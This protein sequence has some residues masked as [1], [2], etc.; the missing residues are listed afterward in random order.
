PKET[1]VNAQLH[2][3]RNPASKS[4]EKSLNLDGINM[5]LKEVKINKKNLSPKDYC[6]TANDLTIFNVP[7]KFILKTTVTI[8]PEKNFT[9]T[10]LYLTNNNFCT[11]NEPHGFRTI[12]YFIDRPDVLTKFSTTIIANKKKYPV[13]LSNGNLISKK[14]IGKQHQGVWQDPFPKSAYLFALVAG[15]FAW[16][17][18]YHKTKSGRKITLR[19]FAQPQQLDQTHHAMFFLKQAMR[20]EEDA[21]GLEYDLDLYQI[22][23]IND[24]NFGA[25]EN[26]GLNIF[27]SK[28]LLA[29]NDTA[30]DSD[31]KRIASVIA[32]EYFHNWTGNRV[33]CRDWFQIGLKEGLTSL[34]EQL[35]MEDLYGK[36]IN[37]IDTV[38]TVYRR[39][40]A[41]DSGPL[42]HPICLQSYIEVDNF[43]TST[44][45]YKSAEV[46]RMLI[47]IFG[48]KTFRSIISTFLSTFDGSA[49]T[50]EDFLRTAA[51]VTKTNL[52]QFKLWYDQCGTPQLKIKGSFSKTKGYGLKIKQEHKK[53]PKD[54]Y[55]PLALSFLDSFG[56]NSPEKLLIINKK[57]HRFA[58]KNLPAKPTLSLL[59]DFS[60]PV[61][62]EYPYTD[63]E[64]LTLILHDQDPISRWESGQKLMIKAIGDLC[65]K[66]QLKKLPKVLPKM[67]KAILD[68]QKIDLSLAAEML[69]LPPQSNLL[70]L[71]PRIDIEK[72]HTV[73]EFIKTELAKQLKSELLTCYQSN[74][75]KNSYSFDAVSIGKRDLKNKCL[76]YLVHLNS[77]DMFALCTKQLEEAD[78]ITDAYASLVAIANSNFGKRKKI[79]DQYYRKWRRQPNLVNKWLVINAS[80]KSKGT[81]K[82][83]KELL[84]HPGFNFKNPNNV[85]ALIRTFSENNLANFHAV[86]GEGY[87]FLADQII[88]I[89]KFNP[90]LAAIISVPLSSGHKLDVK[91]Q[92][93]LHKQLVRISKRDGLSSNVYEIT[94][95][96]LK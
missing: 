10:G 57:E 89:D 55:I 30:T 18:D 5:D 87:K 86:N 88:A 53:A 74:N 70:E 56:K 34:R 78:N 54:F 1:T 49:V 7:N 12:T 35:F 75:V 76:D 20:W 47:T 52:K 24:L 63:D 72:I 67:F 58:F 9:C 94:S 42:A 93:L 11:Q 65:H 69:D 82:R 62:I 41:E 85:Y 91:R 38:K 50:I 60:A 90:Q 19:I 36:A 33:T 83:I 48:K 22:V 32:H 59:R 73:C 46:A 81:L 4:K 44:V 77:K 17:E 43:Y 27:N 37:R 15:D 26:K 2:I 28:L 25:M 8:C 84:K 71:F 14:T 64:L 66:R 39:Q 61:R 3:K 13:L 45:Y 96:L 21:F 23:A 51:T 92:E 16:I 95:K 31:L 6:V 80:I 68:D 29:S 79:L 40:F